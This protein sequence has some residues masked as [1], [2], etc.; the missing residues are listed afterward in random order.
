MKCKK[1]EGVST[2]ENEFSMDLYH[3]VRKYTWTRI[4]RGSA[5]Q[6]PILYCQMLLY[7]TKTKY[8]K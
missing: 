1:I 7:S 8:N 5:D 2:K 6:E 4:Y 3:I